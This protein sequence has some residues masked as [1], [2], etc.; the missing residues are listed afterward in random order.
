[1]KKVLVISETNSQR[2]IVKRIFQTSMSDYS[3]DF[4]HREENSF[5]FNGKDYTLNFNRISQWKESIKS[6]KRLK[7]FRNDYDSLCGVLFCGHNPLVISSFFRTRELLLIDDGIGTPVILSNPTLKIRSLKFVLKY[8]ILKSILFIFLGM[9]LKGTN[10]FKSKF[11]KYYSIYDAQLFGHLN[12][13]IVYLDKKNLNIR[14]NVT[15]IIGSPI[16]EFNLIEEECYVSI[17]NRLAEK[18]DVT[19]Y[20]PHRDEKRKKIESFNLKLHSKDSF[21]KEITTNGIPNTIIGFTSSVLLEYSSYEG[22]TCINCKPKDLKEKKR[23]LAHDSLIAK[24]S[25]EIEV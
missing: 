8:L 19:E 25:M 2:D 17:V 13:K 24:N 7:K 21:D 6:L 9:R 1:M 4:M 16:S 5:Q 11:D 14:K 23:F 20:F 3:V 15:A 12:K 22:V 18:Y 10:H